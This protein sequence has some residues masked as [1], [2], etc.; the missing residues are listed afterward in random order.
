[1]PISIFDNMDPF[2]CH[3]FKVMKNDRLYMFSDG[4]CDQFG[5]PDCKKF[6]S[7]SLTNTLLETLTPEIKDQKQLVE[8]RIDRWQACIDPKTG[9][10]YS[11]IDDICLMGIMI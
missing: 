7:R 8:S 5:G 6:T 11:Q 4:I 3:E 9:H 2:T 10:T 1:M